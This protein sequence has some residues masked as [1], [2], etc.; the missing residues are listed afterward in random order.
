MKKAFRP[1]A[2][3]LI[4]CDPYFSVWSFENDLN[5]DT[6]RHWTG[7]GQSMCGILLIDGVPYRFMGLAGVKDYYMANG[8]ALKQTSVTVTPTSSV[9]TFSHKACTLKV[10]F[11]TPLLLDRPEVMSRP[12]SYLFYEITPL[13]EGHSFEFYVDLSPE[14]VADMNGQAYTAK[15]EAGHVSM[16]VADQKVLNRDGDDVR[17]DW[18]YA[19]LVHPN[20]EVLPIKGSRWKYFKGRYVDRFRDVDLSKPI[21]HAKIPMLCTHSDKLSD[22]VVFAYD[23]VHSIVHYGKPVDAYYMSVYGSFEAML[24]VAVKE[25]DALRAA[26]AEFDAG[27]MADMQKVSP[28][29]EKIGSLAYR[30]AIAAHK[31]VLADGK[32][33]FL[34]KE[35]FSNGCLATLDVTYPSIPLFL[36]YNPELVRAMMRPLFEFARK[37]AW[38]YEFAPHDCGR[39]PFC[40]GQV[41]GLKN[42][43]L[44]FDKQ[45]PVEECGNAIL[46]VAAC[47]RADGDRSIA[48]ENKDLLEKWA[49]YLVEY[50][51]NPENQL[52]TDDFAGHLA[53]N[54]N[55]SLKA[56]VALGA[57]AQLF[58]APKYAEAAKDMASRWVKDAKKQNGKG[59]RLTFDRDDTWSMKYNIIWDRL[60]GL[61]LFDESVSREEIAR[62]KMQMNRYGVPLDSRSDYTKLDWMAWTTVMADDPAYTKKVYASIARMICESEDRVP[63]TDWYYTSTAK[64]AEFQARSV[65][66]GFYINL[67]ADRFLN[68]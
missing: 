5:A 66:G 14:L 31:L 20:A 63:I 23:D 1:T 50:G 18:G 34:S 48:E 49:D 21:S 58:D 19:H 17:I 33:Y 2:V 42:G 12:V 68:R 41:Y 39:Y 27:M 61:G 24:D 11:L 35:C 7:H 22:T 43:E 40:N 53:H 55:L 16:G 26:C 13:E 64:Q 38:K 3:P 6:T 4:A 65:L 59:Y 32:Q 10:T 54:C 36:I 15:A 46:T 52:C 28:E 47:V 30:Q 44:L 29:Y 9:Y 37:D 45:M 62:Y 60:L 56:I 25:A 51:Y 67:L 8:K 57:Y